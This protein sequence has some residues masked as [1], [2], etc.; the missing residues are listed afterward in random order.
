MNNVQL[1]FTKSLFNNLG[2]MLVSW[3]NEVKIQKVKTWTPAD[4]RRKGGDQRG[5]RRRCA[6]ADIKPH[7]FV[8]ADP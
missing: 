6:D 5:F 3:L 8:G 2:A 1:C 7:R 4:P